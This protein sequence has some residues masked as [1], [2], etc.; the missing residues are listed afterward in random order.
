ML[1]KRNFLRSKGF[2]VGERGRFNDA[3]KTAIREAEESGIVFDN[4]VP[5][6]H[7][8]E[9]VYVKQIIKTYMPEK[10][11]LRVARE[12]SGFNKSNVKVTFVTCSA[13][14]EH[15]MYCAC[16]KILAP[17][18]VRYTKDPLVLIQE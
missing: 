10:E 13:C 17:E 2:N 4:A 16:D 6:S 15:M 7:K 8:V 11:A 12:L 1:N 14:N 5:Q 9:P 18:A 3:M